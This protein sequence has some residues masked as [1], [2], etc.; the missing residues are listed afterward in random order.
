MF[1]NENVCLIN[2]N[3]N[4]LIVTGCPKLIDS[5]NYGAQFCNN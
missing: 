3:S 2:D 5:A 4:F 1:N